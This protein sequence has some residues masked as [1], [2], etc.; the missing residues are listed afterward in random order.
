MKWATVAPAQE[1]AP[2]GGFKGCFAALR[3]RRLSELG[4]AW[5]SVNARSRRAEA[6][7][8]AREEM[9]RRIAVRTGRTYAASTI[10][11]WAARDQWPPGV[12]PF[13]LQRWATID[14]AGGIVALARKLGVTSGRIVSW[15]DSPDPDAQ[16][17]LA[18]AKKVGDQPRTIGVAVD[19][20]A[21]IGTTRIRKKVPWKSGQAYQELMVP[22]DSAVF[23]AWASE[24]RA[25]LMRLLGPIIADQVISEFASADHYEDVSYTVTELIRFLPHL[26]D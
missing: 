19:G 22:Q 10:R 24:D 7:R 16:L 18:G 25:G 13:W 14:R 23:D 12:E 3:A 20:Y 2:R 6:S 4:S 17:P 1:E 8:R 21:T 5:Q 26:D 15:R 9:I 11:R